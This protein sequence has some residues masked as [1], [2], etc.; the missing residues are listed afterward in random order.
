MKREWRIIEKAAFTGFLYSIQT[1]L[2][3]WGI[4][5]TMWIEMDCVGDLEKAEERLK[6]FARIFSIPDRVVKW[7]N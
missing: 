1:R 2:V 4:P 7:G 6:G 5:V 3:F